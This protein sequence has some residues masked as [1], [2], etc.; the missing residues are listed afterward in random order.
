MAKQIETKPTQVV[1]F[2]EGD[3]DEVLFKALIEHYR[4]DLQPEGCHALFQQTRSQVTERILARGSQERVSDPDNMLFI[5]Y[6][7]L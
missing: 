6:R 3:T 5:R 2:V 7:C 4:T 1:I